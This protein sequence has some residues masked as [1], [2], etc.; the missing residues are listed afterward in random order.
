MVLPGSVSGFWF[1]VIGQE[2]SVKRRVQNKKT[3][4]WSDRSCKIT[5]PICMRG[6]SGHAN[7]DNYGDRAKVVRGSENARP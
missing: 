3:L 5:K 1:L 4:L 2:I 6:S 7:L